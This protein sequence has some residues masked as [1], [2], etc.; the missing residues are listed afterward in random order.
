MAAIS[1]PPMP[2]RRGLVGRLRAELRLAVAG[3]HG[4]LIPLAYLLATHFGMAARGAFI[5]MTATEGLLGAV[6]FLAFR[7]GRWKKR[8]L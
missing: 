2:H 4:D 3:T 1:P 5:A 7:R 6:S 8:A